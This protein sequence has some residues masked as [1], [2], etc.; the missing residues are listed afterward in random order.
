MNND[1]EFLTKEVIYEIEFGI[2]CKA[3]ETLVDFINETFIPLCVSV[4]IEPTNKFLFDSMM[5]SYSA[6]EE[7]LMK[8]HRKKYSDMNDYLTIPFLESIRDIQDILIQFLKIIDQ[9][10]LFNHGV[11]RLIEESYDRELTMNFMDMINIENRVA[12]INIPIK[13]FVELRSKKTSCI[14][15]RSQN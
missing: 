6:A 10:W 11:H 13:E 9:L 2:A 7:I 15:S 3:T 1:N 4:G 14:S 5:E 8:A 12:I